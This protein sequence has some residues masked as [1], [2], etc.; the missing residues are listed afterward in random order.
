MFERTFWKKRIAAL[1]EKRNVLW[2]A[3]VRRS[4]KTVLCR[5]LEGARYHDCELPRVRRALEDPELFF[6]RQGP[7]LVVL[8]E[9]HR[10]VNPSEVLKIAADH[11]PGT[12]VVGTGSSTL[13]ARRKFRDTLTGRKHELW[14]LPTTLADLRDFG[15]SDLDE[16][17]LRGG[18]PP[19]LLGAG[20]DD[21]AY[22]EWIDSFWAKDL[23]DLFTIDRKAAFLKFVE[24]VFRRSGS[25]FEATAFSAPCE[26]ARQTIMNYLEI[27]ET[28]L[29]A[30]ALRPY[31]G[32]S[33]A[34]VKA[35]RKV[36]A[37]DTGLVC[38][39]RD[40]AALRDDDRG[41]LL[42]HLVLNELLAHA[43]RERVFYWRDKQK[44]EVDFVVR[45]GRGADVMAVEC[46]ARSSRLD[47]AGLASFRARH[48]KGRNLV[49][50]LDLAEPATVRVGGLEVD[51]VPFERFDEELA[52]ISWGGAG[53]GSRR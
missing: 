8:D 30:V 13:A 24:L 6:R 34:E 29:V 11:F 41:P 40:L 26:V 3:G 9:I 23:Q 25:L 31:T 51:L 46:K 22:R 49:V 43:P 4:G 7:G 47:P 50:C 33:A 18:L 2:L 28:T 38:Y 48:P 10:L 14:L 19:F 17:M 44:H 20:V 36:Y 12:R 35:Q 16:R 52:G 27:I 1:L 53:A 45:P 37:F 39:Y 42:E 32:A 21:D 5:G 15:H